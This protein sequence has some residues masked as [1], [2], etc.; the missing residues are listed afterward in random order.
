[1]SP[2]ATF[3][4]N[5][6]GNYERANTPVRSEPPHRSRW[7]VA[8]LLHPGATESPM[9]KKDPRDKIVAFKRQKNPSQST[10]RSSVSGK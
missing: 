2:H 6:F 4:A 9:S 7:N 3:L 8:R 1:M 5:G 10:L